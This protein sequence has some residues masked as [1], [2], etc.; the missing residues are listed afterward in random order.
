MGVAVVTIIIGRYIVENWKKFVAHNTCDQ[1]VF[2]TV[3]FSEWLFVMMM[4]V[5]Y[6]LDLIDGRSLYITIDVAEETTFHSPAV[7]EIFVVKIM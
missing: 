6:A 4:L 5:S 7:K 3:A 2:S 1:M